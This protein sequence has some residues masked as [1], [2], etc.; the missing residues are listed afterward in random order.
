MDSKKE[1]EVMRPRHQFIYMYNN[2]QAKNELLKELELL[3]PGK[4]NDDSDMVVSLDMIGLPNIEKKSNNLKL[5]RI[6]REYLNI[7][8]AYNILK[9]IGKDIP[10]DILDN[11]ITS[12]LSFISFNE[13][14]KEHS[15]ITSLDQ[16]LIY[17]EYSR[18]LYLDEYLNN[19]IANNNIPI[20][21]IDLRTFIHHTKRMMRNDG[22]FHIFASLDDEVHPASFESINSIISTNY[23]RDLPVKILCEP[24][25]WKTYKTL[26]N[27]QIDYIHDYGIVELDDSYQ[28]Y[29][30]KIKEKKL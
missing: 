11:R 5:K 21:F 3:Y 17:L 25:A 7:T 22:T 14:D 30:K 18:L 6:A 9:K 19:R 23:N 8:I 28:K 2:K 4:Y 26:D 29:K 1:T 10:K 15:K 20:K 13:M 12:L 27:H 24:D 16:L